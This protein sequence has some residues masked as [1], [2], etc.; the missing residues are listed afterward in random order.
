M[1]ILG[2]DFLEEYLMPFGSKRGCALLG[3]TDFNKLEV[4]KNFFVQHH[5][6]EWNSRDKLDDHFIVHNCQNKVQKSE[7]VNMVAN[8][9]DMPYIIF[10][11]S[12]RILFDTD[13]IRMFVN[14]IDKDEYFGNYSFINSKGIAESFSTSSF[15]IFLGNENV[16]PKRDKYPVESANSDHIASFCTLIHCYNFN[17]E[18]IV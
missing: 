3:K 18:K 9:R 5:I 4:V 13:I 6:T 2:N 15:Y 10:D 8:H 1:N 16:L 11:N 12:Q 17:S 14:L 7:I